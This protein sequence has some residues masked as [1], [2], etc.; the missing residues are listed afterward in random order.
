MVEVVAALVWRDGKILIC[1]R[2]ADK[3]RA[4]LWEFPGGKVEAGETK[5][6]A[7]VR[8][9]REELAFEVVPGSVFCEVTHTYPDITIH[10]TLFNCTAKG[11]PQRLEHAELSWVQP[12]DVTAYDFCPADKVIVEKLARG[13]KLQTERLEL[14]EL[15]ASD[16]DNLRPILQDADVMYAWEAPFTDSEA[17]NWLAEN[18]RRYKTDGF[19]FWSVEHKSDGAFIGVCGPL[20]ETINGVRYMGVAYI[21]AKAYWGNGYAAEAAAAC[22]NYAFDNLSADE[23]IAEIRPENIKSRRVAERLGM[24][25]RGSFVKTYKGKAMPHLIYALAKEDGHV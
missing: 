14:R 5:Q 18:L 11:E 6:Q 7:L 3:A 24:T 10:L 19:S 20:I 12:Q 8:E 22:V 21:F 1:R 13:V 9:C 2:P 23:V 15:T 16:I 17:E 4:L 25:V